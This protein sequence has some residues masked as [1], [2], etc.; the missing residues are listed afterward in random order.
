M[1]NAAF[2]PVGQVVAGHSLDR[3]RAPVG[4][5]IS[6][7]LSGIGQEMPKEHGNPI[8]AVV[9]R[10]HNEGLTNAVP[11]EGRVENRLQ[12]IAV[13][14][15]I[16]PVTLPLEAGGDGIVPQGLLTIA[17]V[18][19]AGVAHHQVTGNHGHP[20]HELPVPVLLRPAALG[21]RRVVF[22]SLFAVLPHPHQG[23]GKLILVVDSLL[24][25]ARE[26][27]HVH[28]FYPHAQVGLKEGMIHD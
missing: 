5:H 24:N 4:S 14:E 6:E 8:E 18:R 26:L 25:P 13:G 22:L 9:L 27:S 2:G 11:V 17:Q 3:R 10:G 28:R 12:E 19:Q 23:P 20:D 7:D 15:M 1:D 16:G 21:L